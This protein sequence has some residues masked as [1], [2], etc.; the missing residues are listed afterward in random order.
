MEGITPRPETDEDCNLL[1]NRT[2]ELLSDAFDYAHILGI[3]TCAGTEAPL[4]IPKRVKE[5]L[6]SKGRD[7]ADPA[8]VQQTYEAMFK[9]IMNTYK[10]DYYWLWTNEGWIWDSNTGEQFDAVVED[11][12]LAYKALKNVNAPFAMATAG[13]VVGPQGDRAGFD[14][15]LPKDVAISAISQLVGHRP[16]DPSFGDV[17][18]RETWAIPWMEDDLNLSS[19]Q[20]WVGRTRRDAADALAYGCSG[21]MGL[22]WRTRICAPNVAALAQAGWDQSQWNPAPGKLPKKD[23]LVVPTPLVAETGT[24]VSPLAGSIAGYADVDIKGTEDDLLYQTCRYDT[25]GYDIKLP[26]G[27]YKVTLGFCEPHFSATDQRIF[28]VRIAGSK[29]IDKLDIFKEEGQFKALD[30]TFDNIEVFEGNLLIRLDY[31]K[32]LPCISAIVIEGKDLTQKINCGGQNYKDYITDVVQVTPIAWQGPRGAF[33]SDDFYDDWAPAMFGPSVAKETAELFKR[34][35][36]RIPR[37]ASSGVPSGL[38]EDRRPW[39][40][41]NAEYTFVDDLQCLQPKVLGKGNRER[42][43]YWLNT[44]RY[45]RLLAKI[46]CSLGAFNI[47]I[48]KANNQKNANEQEEIANIYALPAY[49]ELIKSYQQA[50]EMLLSTVSTKG[51]LAT[52]I[53][54]EQS[55]TFWSR[56][57]EIPT[58]QLSKVLSRKMPLDKVFPKTFNG[59][60]KIIVPTVRTILEKDENLRLKVIVLD[61][62]AAKEVSVNFRPMGS[63]AEYTNARLN[64]IAR[65]TFEITLNGIAEDI[66]YHI[67]ANLSGGRKLTYPVAA[68]K[69]N[70]TV[71]LMP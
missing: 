37:A 47:A 22:Q 8:I 14:S 4:T 42:F 18:D 55:K 50:Y 64:H 54:L 61:T 23:Q 57:V 33:S 26:N 44:F 20:L 5:R 35:D 70:Q 7:P 48:E 60:P 69:L 43:D 52:V 58:Q 19:P 68:P 2:G 66:E 65:G 34:I 63:N 16:V 11:M 25:K 13:W 24:F 3:K 28:D 36:G 71:I 10:I 12:K 31:I 51:G 29:V 40:K 15:Q 56:A 46:Q 6:I 9:R 30:Y 41:V 38:K 53:T 17:K 62:Q 21:L 39:N 1:F 59:Q 32:S 27:K 67:N 49:E 45:Q